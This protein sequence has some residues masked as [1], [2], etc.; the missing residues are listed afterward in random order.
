ME[1]LAVREHDLEH[2][3]IFTYSLDALMK[4]G[5]ICLW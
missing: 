4:T 1:E 5:K 3:A 2:Y